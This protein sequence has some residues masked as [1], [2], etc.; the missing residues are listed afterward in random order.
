MVL[1]LVFVAQVTPVVVY[2]CPVWGGCAN[3]IVCIKGLGKIKEQ[4]SIMLK[5]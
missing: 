5:N 2:P 4:Q 3:A 1:K